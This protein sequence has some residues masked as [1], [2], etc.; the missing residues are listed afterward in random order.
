MVDFNLDG[1]RNTYKDFL[2]AYTFLATIKS[3]N[4][5]DDDNFTYLVKSTKL[6]STT[7]EEMEANWQGNKY[8]LATTPTY[9]DFSITF[10]IDPESAVHEKISKW[11]NYINDPRTNMHGD[12]NTTNSYFS[13][14]KLKHLNP[15]GEVKKTYTLVGAWPKV[16]G[17]VTLDYSTKEIASFDVTFSYQYHYI[18]T[19][20]EKANKFNG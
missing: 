5:M 2:R 11:S 10:N 18:D 8:K 20:S 16:V 4:F 6:P 19:I 7:L 3:N 14:I 15:Q 9:D 1:F 13:E 17:E 12:P